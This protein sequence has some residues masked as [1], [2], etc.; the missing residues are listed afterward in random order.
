VAPVFLGVVCI[1]ISGEA[2][3][4][5][6]WRPGP[7]PLPAGDGTADRAARATYFDERAARV[8]YGQR[9]DGTRAHRW[10]EPHREIDDVLE[11]EAVE[12]LELP[13]L[14][15]ARGLLLLHV[16]A[17]ATDPHAVQASWARLVRWKEGDGRVRMER[18]LADIL[19]APVGL[20][21]RVGHPFHV[22]Y[23]RGVEAD[24]AGPLPDSPLPPHD[25]WLFVLASAVAPGSFTP[26]DDDH[27]LFRHRLPLSRD[28]SALVLRD[29][30]AFVAQTAA[31]FTRGPAPLY[32]RSI[33]LDALALGVLQQLALLALADRL[34]ALDD[35]GRH[36]RDV[37]RLE[38][39]LSHLRN[40]L[41]WQHLTQHSV[42]NDL[43]AALQEQRRLPDLLAQTV[44]EL[45]DYTRQ[46]SLRFSRYL[47][48]FVAVLAVSGLVAAVA[49]VHA[50]YAPAA[51]PGVAVTV[52]LVALPV[53]ALL[54]LLLTR[55]GRGPHT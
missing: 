3:P 22:A 47:N 14:G 27:A 16:R 38:A 48:L 55:G 12:L 32:V 19:G 6:P 7:L 1:P 21:P 17:D 39:S 25:Q 26:H 36:P 8:L 49:Q 13:I 4:P 52:L 2:P 54:T 15:D 44:D 35:P 5:G 53:L 34:A 46:A 41:W 37:E 45:E 9:S 31:P 33:Y 40:S 20:A 30:A 43:L 10:V 28:W 50:L 11:V 18:L 24:V 23:L 29:G 42:A 51:S